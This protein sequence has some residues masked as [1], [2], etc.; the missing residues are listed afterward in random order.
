MRILVTG[1]AGFIGGHLVEEL[2][3]DSKNSVIVVDDESATSSEKFNWFD[4]AENHRF[5]ILDKNSLENIFKTKIDYVFH[6][7]AET[8]ISLAIQDPTKCF[9]V[10]I[11]GTIN[12]LELSRKYKVK[13]VI[14]AS[15]SSI[16]G[17]NEPPHHEE[18]KPD[19]LN[20]YA[21]SKLCD[22]YICKMYSKAFKL[23][24]I[25]FRFCNVYG[26]R[27][28]NKGQYAPVLAIFQKQKKENIPL[29]ITGDGEQ[30][31]DFIHVK[32]VIKG[33]LCAIEAEENFSQGN[34]Y[35]LGFGKNFSINEVAKMFNCDFVYIEKREG[36]A[37]ETLADIHKTKNELKW[38]PKIKLEDWIENIL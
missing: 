32:D 11:L 19:C 33:L 27:M 22:E 17:L 34:V 1:G 24:T 35:N 16:Y 15:S 13:K 4:K 37:K 30:R 3:K 31:R 25:L 9:E 2:L 26:E 6:L 14:L 28:P 7:A 38:Q 29:T 36:D 23:Q 20:P 10:N 12:I 8:K 5:S 21:A 18:L